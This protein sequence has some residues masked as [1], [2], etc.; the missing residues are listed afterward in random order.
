MTERT[1]W[2]WKPKELQVV[3]YYTGNLKIVSF[4]ENE[5]LLK[6]FDK[7]YCENTP[8]D[9]MEWWPTSPAFPWGLF[10]STLKR[11]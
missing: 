6:V 11:K 2:V 9:G 4:K 8:F 3:R 1:E 5:E 7:D 10:K